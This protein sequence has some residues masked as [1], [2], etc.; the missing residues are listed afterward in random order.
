M[1]NKILTIT[2]LGLILITLT[3]NVTASSTSPLWQIFSE[4]PTGVSVFED[5]DNICYVYKG[6]KNGGISCLKQ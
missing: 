3:I 4:P 6:Y 5:R 1:T 2:L